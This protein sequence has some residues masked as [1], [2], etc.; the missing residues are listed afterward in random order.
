V[1][2]IQESV[3]LLTF[4]LLVILVAYLVVDAARLR[5]RLAARDKLQALSMMGPCTDQ[6]PDLH[7]VLDSERAVAV[8]SP[9]PVSPGHLKFSAAAL[10]IGAVVAAVSTSSTPREG[11]PRQPAIALPPDS[12]GLDLQPVPTSTTDLPPAP[13]EPTTAAAMAQH[14]IVPTM[15]PEMERTSSQPTPSRPPP[16]LAP[17]TSPPSS[18]PTTP[19]STQSPPCVTTVQ[20][21]TP[22]LPLACPIG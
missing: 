17:T 11:M 15:R 10:V 20:V 13:Q 18:Q 1:Q 5:R 8:R 21:Q 22:A 7:V 19:P 16:S 3:V 9:Y 12:N 14:V 4:T 6:S 2:I